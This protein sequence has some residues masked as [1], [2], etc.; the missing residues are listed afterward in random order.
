MRTNMIRP[1]DIPKFSW[2]KALGISFLE[3][4]RTSG[5][6]RCPPL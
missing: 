4:K 6:S 5:W 3:S 1:S 2:T